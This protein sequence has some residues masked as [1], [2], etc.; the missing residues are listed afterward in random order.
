MAWRDREYRR[1]G[2]HGELLRWVPTGPRR[3]TSRDPS[4]RGVITSTQIAIESVS[5]ALASE[6]E[7]IF[8]GLLT[9]SN[10]CFNLKNLRR[11]FGQY[12]VNINSNCRVDH[13]AQRAFPKGTFWWEARLCCAKCG[14]YVH[15]KVGRGSNMLWWRGIKRRGEEILSL[16]LAF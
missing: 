16:R 13:K 9:R 15:V 3:T 1:Q 8:V 5:A 7:V 12:V 14:T 6:E 11:F 4:R 10:H 2:G